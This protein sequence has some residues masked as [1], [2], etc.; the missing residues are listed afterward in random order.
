VQGRQKFLDEDKD[1]VTQFSV[2]ATARTDQLPEKWRDFLQVFS[3]VPQ[4]ML[5][6]LQ[7]DSLFA[8]PA[9]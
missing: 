9:M 7:S 6:K 5:W 8:Q 1:G 3:E 2:R 4:K